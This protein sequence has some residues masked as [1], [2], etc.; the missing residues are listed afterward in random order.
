[1]KNLCAQILV[2]LFFSLVFVSSCYRN[3][4]MTNEEIDKQLASNKNEL[5]TRT[6]SK[7]WE[8]QPFIPGVRGGTL[9]DSVTSD[10]KSFNLLIGERDNDTATLLANMHQSLLDYDYVNH[11]FKPNCASAEIKVD[12]INET[13]TVVYTLRDDLFWSFFGSDK[14][15]KVT[16]DDIIFW[17]NEIEGDPVFRSSAYNSQ[18]VTMKDGSEARILIEKID[19]RRFA[20]K[21][22]RIDANPLLSTNRNFGPRFVYEKAKKE[23]GS[24]AVFD[25]FSVATDPK[26]IP[27][28]GMWF[29]TEYTPGQRLVFKRNGD[30]WN[31]DTLGV[32][33]PYQDEKIVLIVPDENTQFL[34][35]KEG[36]LETYSVRPENFD[37]VI[38]RE[39]PGY[40]VFNAEGSL[41]AQLWSFNQNPKS[42]E[43]PTYDWFTKK[44]FRQAMSC[45]LNR[46]RIIAQTY[47]GL[48]DPKITFF[49]EPNPYYNPDIRLAYLFN[50][51]EALSLFSS[52][53]MNRDDSGILRDIKG[54]SVEFDLTIAADNTITNDIASII[55]D[56]CAKVGV[57]VRVR[58]LDF[59]KIVEQLSSTYEWQSII[60][61]LGANY[62]PTQGSNVWVSDGNLHL[63]Y[64]LQEKPATEWEARIDYLYNEGSY[65]IDYEKAKK[66]WDEYQSILLEQCP[67]VYLVRP[68]SFVAISNRWDFSNV[69]YDNIGGLQTDYMWLKK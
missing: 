13:L 27:S 42:A 33:I 31:K 32:S 19:E 29:L 44:E 22:P 61:G 2:L 20:F 60:I 30:Y 56:E 59:Q 5:L 51:K 43:S 36:K 65:T 48:A 3:D 40:T 39:N 18:F 45:L 9:F 67:V 37:E 57:T 28:M 11:I 17:Y 8:G 6:M 26:K 68:R 58:A 16:S 10:P 12:T 1:M 7:P 15:I 14:K 46:D 54:R 50:P 23:G 63:W 55:V 62:W 47:R 64:P 25:L 52:I 38:N 24:K 41:G 21:F 69:Y 66:I 53:G 49:P 35:F 4:E 34:L